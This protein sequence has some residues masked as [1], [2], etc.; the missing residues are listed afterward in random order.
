MNKNVGSID[1]ALRLIIGAVLLLLPMI[2]GPGL[3]E[4]MTWT[5][6]SMFIGVVLI[7]TALLNFCPL[8]RLLGIHAGR[9]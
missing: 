5:L 4:N 1:R 7:G 2:S 9:G 3:F 6:I 8:Y